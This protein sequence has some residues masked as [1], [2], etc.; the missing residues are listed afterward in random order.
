MIRG[1]VQNKM[2]YAQSQNIKAKVKGANSLY[3][4]KC[5]GTKIYMI[6][7][8]DYLWKKTK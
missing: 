6:Y 2:A 1:K 4:K 7:H 3:M 8:M 5:P